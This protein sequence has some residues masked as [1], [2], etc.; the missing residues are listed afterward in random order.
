MPKHLTVND[1][2]AFI[3]AGQIGVANGVA[4]L[5]S[6]GKVPTA[7][8]PTSVTG[9]V[10]SVDGL[11]GNV[12]LTS[13]Y[14]LL[15]TSSR[16]DWISPLNYE[17]VA[18]GTTDDHVAIQAAL[19]A[20]PA[21]GVVF[22]GSRKYGL[23]AKITVPPYVTLLGGFADRDGAGDPEAALIPLPGFS[24][25]MV[26]E[27][28][29][30]VTGAYGTV[31]RD[32]VLANF[33][34]DGRLL[35][36]E[37]VNGVQA[38]GLVH[39][40][41]MQNVSVHKVRGHAVSLVSNSSGNPYSWHLS[42]VQV[43]GSGSVTTWDGFHFIGTDHVFV[44]C[45]TEGVRGNGFYL[46][47]CP[48]S[49]LTGCRAEWSAL[50]GFYIT[51][52]YGSVQGSGSILLSGCSTDRSSQYGVLIDS[53]GT[54]H[55]I[56]S[57]LMARRDGRNGFPGT[58]GGGYAAV[59]VSSATTPVLVT[60]LSCFP[61]VGD[62]GLGVNSPERGISVANSTYCMV[63]GSYLHA[64]LT[65]YHD[66][67]GNGQFYRGPNVATATG[68]TSAP[69]RSTTEPA[70]LSGPL[71]L[72][73]GGFLGVRGASGNTLLN[74]QV[75]GDTNNRVNISA[76][77]T[78]TWG[79]GGAAPDTTLAR[80]GV[81]R[82]A[83]SGDVSLFGVATTPLGWLNVKGPAYGALGD[84]TTDDTVAIQ[85]AID[86]AA[87]AGGGTVYFPYGVYRTSNALVLKTGVTLRGVHSTAW[88]NRFT[89]ALCS[90]KATASFAGECLIS[91]LGSDITGSGHNEGNCRIFD[92]E[93]DGSA[94]STGSVSGIHA[95]GE[96]LDVMLQRVMVRNMTH[97]GIHTNVGTGTKAP[98]DW[99]FDSVVAYQNAQ[100]G[101]S[102]SM[103]DGYVRNCVATT[104]GSDGWFLGPFGSLTMDSCQALWNT[105]HGLTIGGGSQV[106]NLTVNSFLTDR[107]GHD[108]IH[109]GPSSGSG[110]PPFVLTGITLNRDGRNSKAGGA[111]YAGLRIDGCANPVI[112]NGL[113]VNTG[114]D[115]DAT[116]VNS[117][118]YGIRLTATNAY[119]QVNGGYV[120]G[121][122]LGWNDDGTSTIVRRFNV[123]EAT[124]L[125][126]APVFAYGNSVST[127]GS[128]LDVPGHAMGL[129]SPREHGAIAWSVNPRSVRSDK[130]TTSGTLYLAALYVPR[131][132]TAVKLFWGIN[133]AGV[134]PTAGQNFVGLY[135]AAGTQ[136]ASV[137]VDARVTTTGP[138]PEAI[139]TALVP[140]MYWAAFLFN[141][142]TPPRLYV[143]SDL[144]PLLINFNLAGATLAFATN[145]T[146]LTA[147]PASFSP[148]SNVSSQFCLFSALA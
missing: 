75:T 20:A 86:A 28:V 8:L 58:G 79:S 2:S 27:L 69:V 77:G 99:S 128:S 72:T 64:D 38:S 60:G 103:T 109:L 42:N 61:G 51:G 89:T 65:P 52:S 104:N 127:Y 18:D 73:Q 111:G 31:S 136:L 131:P 9:S 35:T 122:T 82:L 112:I 130:L 12:D 15:S 135:S 83:L 11:I 74:G 41:Q 85:A 29:D 125:R 105:N 16:V 55:V 88:A 53:T 113:N 40:V 123:D 6:D 145:G 70:A 1:E 24:S 96:V 95:Q 98:H 23:G 101:F 48:N 66:G 91:M 32:A 142:A 14:A 144:N 146:G 30:Q 81:N 94:M 54:G 50:N 5:G 36:T 92:L 34:I 143:G 118:Q 124:G 115:D 84:G 90:L 126:T 13:R 26:V 141:A 47:G 148:S 3:T 39:G 71:T 80:S 7:Q 97:N 119:V 133:T 68:I 46:Q 19:N 22:L 37:S 56:L 139:S 110:S 114:V 140:G 117:P 62:D 43:S 57:G 100:F 106:G 4:G 107:N 49:S 45:R 59:R 17:A 10:I 116:G 21:G 87:A 138:F 129:P 121:D 102:M 67:G 63:T 76:G 25:P 137:G 93:L 44:D 78:V 108:G 147:L 134:T 33:T 120:H 132:A